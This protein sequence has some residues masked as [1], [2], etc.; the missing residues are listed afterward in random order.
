MARIAI[1]CVLS[2]S[3]H[4]MEAVKHTIKPLNPTCAKKALDYLTAKDQQSSPGLGY[5][6]H[7]FDIFPPVEA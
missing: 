5:S 7:I 2:K 6:S 1:V 3:E 4:I